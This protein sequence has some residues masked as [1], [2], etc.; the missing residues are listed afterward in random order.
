MNKG[1]KVHHKLIPWEKTS[2]EIQQWKVLDDIYDIDNPC[3]YCLDHSAIEEYSQ[4]LIRSFQIVHSS[5]IDEI[6]YNIRTEEEILARK[7]QIQHDLDAV[8]QLISRHGGFDLWE[9]EIE[10]ITEFFKKKENQDSWIGRIDQ[11]H[12]N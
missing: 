11:A 2:E 8:D 7:D 6:I 3:Y 5:T 10:P 1:D 9:K 12:L 4:E